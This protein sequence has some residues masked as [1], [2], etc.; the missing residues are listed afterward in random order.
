MDR[1]VF[2]LV[3]VLAAAFV[4][5]LCAN[6]Q[7]DTTVTAPDGST[8]ATPT[9][10]TN[11]TGDAS[12][13]APTD[14]ST[15]TAVDVSTTLDTAADTTTGATTPLADPPA[16]PPAN[17]GTDA[18]TPPATTPATTPAD[19]AVTIPVETPP[20]ATDTEGQTSTALVVVSDESTSPQHAPP[21]AASGSPPP[22]GG[23]GPHGPG[24]GSGGGVGALLPGVEQQLHAVQGQ[25]DDMQRQLVAGKP[26][27]KHNLIRLR[28]S[29]AQIA[30]ALLAL[31]RR[32]DATGQLTPRL[33]RILQRVRAHLSHT[34]ASAAELI[35][36][37]RGSGLRGRE[38]QLLIDELVRFQALHGTP[39][40][41]PVLHG[42]PAGL[43]LGPHPSLP[44]A[45]SAWSPDVEQPPAAGHATHRDPGGSSGG[46]A[47][48]HPSK[49]FSLPGAAAVSSSGAGAAVAVGL[50]AALL[51]GVAAPRL[52]GRITVP[53]GLYR[54]VVFLAPLERPG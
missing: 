50:L 40:A 25:I 6:A 21:A 11:A 1:S 26:P 48:H 42:P 46:G 23:T 24:P 45:P 52:S 32:L 28:S 4:V 39:V 19:P 12:T 18:T 37:L 20:A 51:L 38:L 3:A 13:T 9:P 15:P 41:G 27:S 8:D 7:A 34:Q 16:T 53:P 35:A 43:A 47:Q 10:A 44:W 29:L 22:G 14:V 17:G 5:I 30:P 49:L 36:A 2:R 33:R 54:S 31:E